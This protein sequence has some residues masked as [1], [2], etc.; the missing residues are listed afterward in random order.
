MTDE[1]AP[2]SEMT[3]K[4]WM[5]PFTKKNCAFIFSVFTLVRNPNAFWNIQLCLPIHL[6][7][8]LMESAHLCIWN[9]EK[10]GENLESKK[11]IIYNTYCTQ[12]GRKHCFEI[13]LLDTL[14][15]FVSS[16]ECD[17]IVRLHAINGIQWNGKLQRCSLNL[18]LLFSNSSNFTQALI[19][20]YQNSLFNFV[21]HHTS[22]QKGFSS[23]MGKKFILFSWEWTYTDEV[24]KVLFNPI[25]TWNESSFLNASA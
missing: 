23:L 16:N 3:F 6:K 25:Q 5:F 2:F 12:S 11:E 17:E 9:G 19:S 24:I 4:T 15:T 21:N 14:L 1:R 22:K 7:C 13:S 18:S 10:E 8:M 20:S